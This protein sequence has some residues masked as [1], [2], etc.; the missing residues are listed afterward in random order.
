MSS[1]LD[2][3]TE[4]QKAELFEFPMSLIRLVRDAVVSLTSSWREEQ[5]LIGM[6]A[7]ESHSCLHQH[8]EVRYLKWFEH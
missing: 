7:A 8:Q 6:T 4:G 5:S 1:T 3:I 2:W